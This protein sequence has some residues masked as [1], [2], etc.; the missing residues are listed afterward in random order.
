MPTLQQSNFQL[1]RKVHLLIQNLNHNN[2]LIDNNFSEPFNDLVLEELILV[3]G[4][5]NLAGANLNIDIRASDG[6]GPVIYDGNINPTELTAY[7]V[8]RI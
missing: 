1:K 8:H 7:S 2:P 3:I 5:S 4:A 6:A